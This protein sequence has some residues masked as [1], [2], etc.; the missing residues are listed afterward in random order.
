[1]DPEYRLLLQELVNVTLRFQRDVVMLP[2]QQRAS[3]SQ[4]S[5]S[6]N[7][8]VEQIADTPF[9]LYEERHS[10]VGFQFPT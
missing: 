9:G 5:G 10:G 6:I 1:V 2:L 3:P 8:G 7:G 4:A